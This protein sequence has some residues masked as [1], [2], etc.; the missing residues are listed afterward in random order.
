MDDHPTSTAD[1][2]ATE[3][4]G[5][6]TRRRLV[7]AR[8]VGLRLVVAVLCSSVLAAPL[9][10]SWAVTHTGVHG[11]I[12]TSP[13]TFS[14]TT[15]GHTELRLGIAG[16]VYVPKSRGPL[17]VI[18]T[19]EGPG[20]PGAGDGDL[21]NYVRPE[22]LEL[23]TG[24][25]HDP[26]RAVKEYVHLVQ[27]EFEHQ[28][29]LAELTLAGLGGLI[30]LA[31]SYL[32]PRQASRSGPRAALMIVLAG[33]VVLGTTTSLAWV[34]LAATGGDSAG[35]GV[36]ELSSLD[37]TVAAGST[38]NSPV[39]RALL[40]GALAKSRQL[41]DRQEAGERAY[42]AVAERGLAAQ[43]GAMEGPADGETAVM[44]QSD[45]HCNITMIRLQTLVVS[46]LREQYGGDVPA[47]LAIAGD[48]TTNG[49]GAEGVCIRD[50]EAIAV[51][52]P[53][54]A[55]TG[56]HESNVSAV[57]MDEAGMTV[58][59]GSTANLAGVTVLGDGDPSRSEL[60]GK[61][62]LRGDETEEDLGVR[63]F[64]EADSGDRPDL[65]LMHEA[66]AAET[67]LGVANVA[68][69]IKGQGTLTVP[70]EDGVRDVPAGAV[71]YGHWHRS[72]DPR[73]L[74]NSDGSWTLL[75]ELD[76]SGGAIDTPTIG[77]FSTPWSQPQQEASFPVVFLDQASG[78]VTGYQIYSFETDGTATV[79]P[80][81]DVGVP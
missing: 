45:M 70:S 80:R 31:L 34:Q 51:G 55:V 64:E 50:E 79:R 18:A 39:I 25:F 66:Y 53:V 78:M 22:M 40:G 44:M 37:G 30:M 9:A 36:Y 2:V 56:N 27:R 4:A 10:L 5:P 77:N 73:V 26:E 54:A 28:L 81:V 16:T 59:A 19:V 23:Y 1:P 32:L 69:L 35:D 20:D 65:V 61:T 47:L 67:F 12:G 38:T 33:A 3:D 13:T 42:R 6:S 52:A 76:T 11:L 58:L 29:L 46:M 15:R 24:L 71:F 43:A 14:L 7:L 49:T 68:E 62:Q 57:Q 75:M 72:V 21:A 74:W 8:H 17:G 60:F 48:L 41:I 63:L